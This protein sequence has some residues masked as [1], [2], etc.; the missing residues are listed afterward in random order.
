LE[1]RFGHAPCHHGQVLQPLRPPPAPH[2]ATARAVWGVAWLALGLALAWW[3]ADV[4]LLAFAAALVAVL[5]SQLQS[6]LSALLPRALPRRASLAIVVLALL[7]ALALCTAIAGAAVVAELTQLRETLPRA[8]RELLAWLGTHAPGRWALDAIGAAQQAPQGWTERIATAVAR[9]FNGTLTAAVTLLL[10]VMLAVYFAADPDTYRSGLLR[11]LPQ[12]RRASAA[13]TLDAVGQNLARW[14]KGQAASSVTVGVLTAI[15]LTVLG[16]PQ[17]LT[18][19]LLTAV[20]DFVP[21]FGSILAGLIVV[22]VAFGEGPREALWAAV[23]CLV[24]QQL[25][26]YIV[27]PL[28]QRWAVRLAPALGVLSVLMFSLLF[29][30]AG[31]LLAVPL[32]VVVVTLVQCWRNGDHHASG[33]GTGLAAR[34]HQDD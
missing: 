8:W 21:Y 25:E 24:V 34:P 5:L 1:S 27:Q 17:V 18:L 29:G 19:S 10:V 12:E 2:D 32:M 11:L 16:L 7:A 14:L 13:A 3:L 20:L 4:L 28:A 22:A 33:A 6:N 15:G 9:A 30:L 26:A 31:A 23:M